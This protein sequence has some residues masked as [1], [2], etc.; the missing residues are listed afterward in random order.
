M[1]GD[2][3]ERIRGPLRTE[4]SLPGVQ[5]PNSLE[6]HEDDGHHEQ[7]QHEPVQP[8]AGFRA[9]FLRQR[10]GAAA[11][12]RRGEG[13]SRARERQNFALTQNRRH[14]RRIQRPRKLFLE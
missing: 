11:E 3:I 2:E 5:R 10:Y 6:R 12:R 14:A 4:C 1:R 7:V 9:D 13:E 8:D